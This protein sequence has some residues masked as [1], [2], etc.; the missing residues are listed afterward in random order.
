MTERE[1]SLGSDEK[2]VSLRIGFSPG[3]AGSNILDVE[4]NENHTLTVTPRRWITDYIN[5]E[6]MLAVLGK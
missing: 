5:L 1:K 6:E 4:L 3:A 2:E